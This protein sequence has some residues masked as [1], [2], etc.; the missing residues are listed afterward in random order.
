MVVLVLTHSDRITSQTL[1]RD[2]SQNKHAR[3]ELVAQHVC[4]VIYYTVSFIRI[5]LVVLGNLKL[6]FC[7]A[8]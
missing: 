8:V 7:R 6:K 2:L 3:V 1:V 4:S 5:F